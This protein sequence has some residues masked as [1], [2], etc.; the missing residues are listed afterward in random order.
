MTEWLR[1]FPPHQRAGVAIRGPVRRDAPGRFPAELLPEMKRC[2]RWHQR[3]PTAWGP[4][5]SSRSTTAD[6]QERIHAVHLRLRPEAHQLAIGHVWQPDR[7]GISTS[8]DIAEPIP[9]TAPGSPAAMG[10]HLLRRRPLR[11]GQL[12]PRSAAAGKACVTL[13]TGYDFDLHNASD[14]VVRTQYQPNAHHLLE[15]E[16]APTCSASAGS[17]RRSACATSAPAAWTTGP[18]AAGRG[19]RLGH[20][21]KPARHHQGIA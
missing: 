18:A 5:R 20:L 14:L 16:S 11:L 7:R 6:A 8:A 1:L 15:M 12:A 4:R 13:N 21:Q 10:R 3:S 9:A 19:D 2:G 17:A